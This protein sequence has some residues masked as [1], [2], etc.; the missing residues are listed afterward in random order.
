MEWAHV[1]FAFLDAS[2][3]DVIVAFP[4][5]F[6]SRD[7]LITCRDSNPAPWW[8]GTFDGRGRRVGA[9]IL[10]EGDLLSGLDYLDYFDGFDELSLYDAGTADDRLAGIWN[11]SFTSDG[12]RFSPPPPAFVD[13]F[14]ASGARLYLSDGCGL[15]VA[16]TDEDVISMLSARFA[17]MT[18]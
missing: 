1:C 8:E 11:D 16:T 17:P 10:V 3:D 18:E 5:L 9:F 2:I 14:A 13:A 4:E 6:R 15:N 7:C 12:T